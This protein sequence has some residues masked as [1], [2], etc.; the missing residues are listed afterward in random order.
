MVQESTM[1]ERQD[2]ETNDT[3][4]A[5]RKGT[6]RKGGQPEGRSHEQNEGSGAGRARGVRE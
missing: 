5:R 1:K 2:R 3:D 4:E 6:C